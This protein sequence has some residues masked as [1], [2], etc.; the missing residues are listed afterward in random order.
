MDKYIGKLIGNT[1]NPNDIKIALEDSFSA[2]RGEFV[3]I[4]HKESMDEPETWFGAC[5]LRSMSKSSA[6][7][8]LCRAFLLS[9]FSLIKKKKGKATMAFP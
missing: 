8:N 2:K 4:K 6:E 5:A 1:G 3:K 9:S 7:R